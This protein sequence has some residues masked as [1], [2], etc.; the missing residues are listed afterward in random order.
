MVVDKGSTLPQF[1]EQEQRRDARTAPSHNDDHH[2]SNKPGNLNDRLDEMQAEIRATHRMMCDLSALSRSLTKSPSSFSVLTKGPSLRSLAANGIAPLDL[3]PSDP[4]HS[5]D[6]APSFRTDTRAA[7][8]TEAQLSRVDTMLPAP[9]SVLAAPPSSPPTFKKKSIGLAVLNAEFAALRRSLIRGPESRRSKPDTSKD[10]SEAVAATKHAGTTSPIKPSKEPDV[11]SPIHVNKDPKVEVTRRFSISSNLNKPGPGKNRLKSVFV[12]GQKTDATVSPEDILSARN[13]DGELGRFTL[14]HDSSYRSAW[15]L[16]IM[17]MILL[18]VILTPLSLGFRYTPGYLEPLNII[19]T[20]LFVI[21]FVVH[22]FSSYT[23]ERGDLISGPKRTAMNYLL[24]GW[25]IPDF[26]SWFPFELLA[27]SSKGRVLSFTKIFRLAKVSQLARKFNSAKKAGI[28]RFILLLG[29]VLTVVHLL[30]CYWSWV[31]TGWRAHLEENTFVPE[32]FFE[33]YALCWSLIIGCLNAS[34][35]AMYTA[36]EEISVACFMLVGNILQASVFGSVAVLISSFDED[37]AAYNKKIISTSER[38]RFLGIPDGLTKRIRGY[39]ENLWRETKS[40]N[41]DADAFINELSPALICE[42]KFQLYRDMLKQ[43]PFLSAKT[44]APAVIEMLI[45][46]LRTVIYMQ[47]DVLIRKGEFGDW[48][49]FIGSKGSVGVL[50]PTTDTRKI[51]RILR[52]GDYFGE[53]AL[54]QRAKRST[55]AVA[56]TWV[57]IHVLCRNDLDSV[58]E[59]YPTQTEILEREINK[60]MQSKVRYSLSG[61][62]PLRFVTTDTSAE[63]ASSTNASK[64]NS[65]T[66]DTM[67]P[68]TSPAFSPPTFP[69][70]KKSS[71][72]LVVPNAALSVEWMPEAAPSKTETSTEAAHVPS[73]FHLSLPRRVTKILPLS[74]AR[75][76]TETTPCED[77]M[78]G[79]RFSV[80]SI[81]LVRSQSIALMQK[82]TNSEEEQSDSSI[83]PEEIMSARKLEGEMNRFTLRHDSPY[84]AA[85]DVTVIVMILFDLVFTPL[86]LGFDYSSAF[87]D[88][89]SILE[90]VV[91]VMDFFVRIFSSYLDEHGNLISGPKKTAINYV[92]SGWALPDLLSWFPFQFFADP[93]HSDVIGFLKIFRLAKVS[94]LAHRLNSAKKAGIVRFVMLLGL[95]LTISHLLT[96][97]WSWVAVGWRSHL[98]EGAFVPNSL[99]DEYSLCWSLVIGC[100]NASPPVMYTAAELISVACFMLVGNVLQ[101]SVFGAVAALIASFDENEAA[102][103]KKIITTSERCRFLGI[104]D[105]LSKRIRG[106][107]ENLWRE[108]K[109]INADADSFINEL[110]PALIC[111]VKFQLYRDM[112]KQIPFLSSKTLAPAVIEVLV[113]HLRTVIYMQDDVLIRKGEFGDWMGFIGSKGSVGILDPQSDMIKIIL[114]T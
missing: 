106:Y 4:P 70:K 1:V 34:P 110:S 95:V 96:C 84:R 72:P 5:I 7:S 27:S 109:S 74:K 62:T 15:D 76:P 32:T 56:L 107:Y 104:P 14:R 63:R 3:L 11:E 73:K 108:T 71:D 29:I 43:I 35:P 54:L 88:G 81:N 67:F 40:V 12:K 111:E 17:V 24:S 52:K 78:A 97:Y 92:V 6:S 90:S 82:K 31:A 10:A 36:I 100:V 47:D 53:M 26:L 21:D 51:I 44:L 103:S 86:A 68:A 49:G 19:G 50:D 66:T 112:L 79:R 87:L 33:E 85:W 55:T 39:Y 16:L 22:I 30:A 45:S 13:R 65:K 75:K 20:I 28:L 57:Q 25:A 59:Q 41:S 64:I 23:D 18:D 93:S 46:H 2:D 60:Y 69:P 91:F 61:L 113:L 38:C 83:S 105:E 102:Y 9:E 42:V 94:H 99:F 101:A 8:Q 48:M 114:T 89:Y 80:S 77:A 98:N 58:K 37:E